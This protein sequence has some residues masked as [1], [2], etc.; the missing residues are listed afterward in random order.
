M[1]FETRHLD[2]LAGFIRR[3]SPESLGMATLG[4]DYEPHSGKVRLATELATYLS[5]FNH[6]VHVNRFVHAA[7]GL[8]MVCETCG[9]E[10]A[11]WWINSSR[12]RAGFYCVGETNL[13][14]AHKLA[15][16]RLAQ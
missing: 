12:A 13:C 9:A 14:G 6:N 1:V 3:S 7:T 8:A 2:A 15:M 4:Q 5:R 16:E 11:R 10:N